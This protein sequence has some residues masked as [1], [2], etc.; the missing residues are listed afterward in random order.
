MTQAEMTHTG[1]S[2]VRPEGLQGIVADWASDQRAFKKVPLQLGKTVAVF[3][4][5]NA[6]LIMLQVLKMA[7]AYEAVMVGTR[8]FRLEMA[9]RFGATH[10]VNVKRESAVKAILGLYP[11]GIDVVANHTII[12]TPGEVN[13]RYLIR[14]TEHNKTISHIDQVQLKGRLPNGNLVPLNLFSA[15]HSSFGEVKWMVHSSDDNRVK[16]LGG[17]HNDGNS[18][19]IDLQ[20]NA[21]GHSNFIEFIF[22][23]EGNNKHMK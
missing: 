15:V 3:G 10:V 22:F 11:D 4:P 9:K 14:L 7:G 2:L 12:T 6:G 1:E 19:F 20:F 5:G 17:D 16:V 18:E 8:D 13:H 21:P 23:I